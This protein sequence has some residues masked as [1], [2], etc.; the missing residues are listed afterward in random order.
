MI[1]K[2]SLTNGNGRWFLIPLLAMACVDHVPIEGAPC[3][4][5]TGFECCAT[6]ANTCARSCPATTPGSSGTTCLH[7]GDCRQGELCKSWAGG[8]NGQCRRPCG[9]DLTC[10]TG[11]FCDYI[12]H[13]ALPANGGAN[14]VLAC[15]PEAPDARC[16][17]S[18]CRAFTSKDPQAARFTRTWCDTSQIRGCFLTVDPQCGLACHDVLIQDCGSPGCTESGGSIRCLQPT[19]DMP[20]LRFSCSTCDPNAA[21]SCSNGKWIACAE[22]PVPTT[23]CSRDPCEC[24]R[25]CTPVDQ[26]ACP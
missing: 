11:E 17:S 22:M 19:N 21:P 18:G 25:L 26:G 5:P 4:C 1:R 15:V 7:D 10:A 8:G 3:P 14:A 2:A 23:M 6:L 9:S 13:D 12:L 20:C 16:P 24:D